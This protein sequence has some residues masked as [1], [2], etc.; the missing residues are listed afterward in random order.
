MA[1]RLTHGFHP[2]AAKFPSLVARELILEWSDPGNLVLDPFCGS[3]TTLVEASVLGRRGVGVDIHPL[4]CLIASVKCTPLSPAEL[5]DAEH[6][7]VF[8]ALQGGE[9]TGRP[10]LLAE[11]TAASDVTAR[12]ASVKPT[13]PAFHN[14][15]HWF[16]RP[17]QDDLALLR[18]ILDVAP[19]G[20]VRAFLYV[21]FSAIILRCS[22]QDSETR[23]KAVS[24]AYKRGLAFELFA[25][26]AREMIRDM[27]EFSSRG[28]AAAYAANANAQALP[29]QSKVV[30]LVVTSP[31][32]A[33][34]YDYYLYHKQRMNWLGLDFNV[35]KRS[36]IG[37]RLEFSS[38]KAPAEK[39]RADM[40]RVFAEL[41]RVVKPG[42]Q[43]AFVIGDSRIAGKVYS[44]QELVTSLARGVGWQ[45]AAKRSYDLELVSKRFNPKFGERSKK[46][47]VIVFQVS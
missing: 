20:A 4:A 33:N 5:A 26:K 13:V 34:T 27:R 15:D 45:V 40:R 21:A 17:A 11:S 28:R 43:A 23:Y 2:Y 18:A 7:V 9:I 36:E 10:M 38:V 8:A 29:L 35:A 44:G 46:E 37:S 42:A 12:V 1:D 31:P 22:R 25:K 14:R 41:H 47:H 24:R 19:S 16:S 3:G 39:F 32:Y 30:D 6:W